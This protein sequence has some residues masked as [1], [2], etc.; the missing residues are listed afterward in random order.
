MGPA[1]REAL[2]EDVGLGVRAEVQGVRQGSA[3]F[4]RDCRELD[5]FDQLLRIHV[6]GE[7]AE[8][9]VKVLELRALEDDVEVFLDV[10]DVLHALV[11]L[12]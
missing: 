7:A 1:G 8:G 2:H 10:E 5:V 9:E 6:I 12:N 4:A 3:D 11:Q